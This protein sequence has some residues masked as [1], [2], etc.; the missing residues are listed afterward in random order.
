MR[1]RR[2]QSRSHAA[3]PARESWLW[4]SRYAFAL[5]LR[6]RG[7]LGQELSQLEATPRVPSEVGKTDPSRVTSREAADQ[8][9]IQLLGECSW[10]IEELRPLVEDEVVVLQRR[11]GD[12]EANNG[13]LNEELEKV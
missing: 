6:C 10:L 1:Q 8:E 11:L 3:Q 12:A 7:S 5:S 13:Q 4:L 2:F 9:L